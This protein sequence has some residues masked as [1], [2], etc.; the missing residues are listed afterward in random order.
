MQ[1]SGDMDL[2]MPPLVVADAAKSDSVAVSEGVSVSRRSFM[3]GAAATAAAVPV[4]AS[5]PSVALAAPPTE[6]FWSLPRKLNLYRPRTGESVS[7]VYFRNGRID[8]PGY[9]QICNLLRDVRGKQAVQMNPRLL[10]L[11]CAIQAWVAQ[12][13]YN[14][15]L[16]ILSG[17]RSP[18]TNANTEGAARNSMHMYACA[19]DIVMP[20]LP[21]RYLGRLAQHYSAGGVGFY[22]SSGFVH[23]DTGRVRTWAKR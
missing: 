18:R 7:A 4:L 14:K 10:D 20:G 6:A 12:Y 13:G 9:T 1:S 2:P 23:V 21:V 17:Y 16:H 3:L 15:P 19:A 5:M 11:L 22:Y 8:V